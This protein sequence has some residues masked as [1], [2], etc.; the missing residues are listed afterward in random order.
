MTEFCESRL[1]KMSGQAFVCMPFAEAV[2][3]NCILFADGGSSRDQSLQPNKETSK[4]QKLQQPGPNAAQDCEA[5][6]TKGN[7][8]AESASESC[9]LSVC[10]LYLSG[11]VVSYHCYLCLCHHV[12][13]L[14]TIS[15]T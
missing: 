5:T 7:S 4:K 11:C 15:H 10:I 9:L 14:P 12:S 3:N 13:L 6:L 1:P 2:H 8:D